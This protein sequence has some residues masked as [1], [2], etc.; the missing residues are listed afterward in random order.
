MIKFKSAPS[1]DFNWEHTV[2][3][4]DIGSSVPAAFYAYAIMHAASFAIIY[5]ILKTL[6]GS[7]ILT[8][9]IRMV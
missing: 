2:S 4:R 6:P 1:H 9:Q 8:P 3:N 5:H 7:Q